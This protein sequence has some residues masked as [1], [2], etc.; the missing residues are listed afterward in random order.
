[1]SSTTGL[2]I[3]SKESWRGVEKSLLK[4]KETSCSTPVLYFAYFARVSIKLFLHVM[5]I[6]T[7]QLTVL[8]LHVSLVAADF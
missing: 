3:K 2:V 1:M 6:C 8:F 4:V 5:L 7:W